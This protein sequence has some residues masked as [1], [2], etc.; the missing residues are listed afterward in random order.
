MLLMQEVLGSSRP[1]D[2]GM[3]SQWSPFHASNGVSGHAF[4]GSVPFITAANM[5]DNI[6]AKAGLYFCSTFTGWSR[7]NDDKHY[8]SQ[9]CLGWWMGYLSCQAVEGTH[10]ANQHFSVTPLVSPEMT[11]IGLT[12]QH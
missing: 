5:T 1:A 10:R 3:P 12:Y 7:I 9:V 11:G 8:L 4:M 6:W 2:T